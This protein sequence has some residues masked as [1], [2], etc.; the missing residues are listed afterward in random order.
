MGQMNLRGDI[1]TLLDVQPLLHLPARREKERGVVVVLPY[2][3]SS[4]GI[5]VDEVFDVQYVD[6]REI[7]SRS[8]TQSSE[9]KY[10]SGSFQHAD[11]II[12]LLNVPKILAEGD[13]V[14]DEVL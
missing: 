6:Q 1:V 14:V 8:S 7:E 2:Q 3:G 4:V 11:R 13:L 9:T 12:H 10:F 5:V